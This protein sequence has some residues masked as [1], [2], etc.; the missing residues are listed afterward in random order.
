MPEKGKLNFLKNLHLIIAIVIVIIV[1]ILDIIFTNY[2][3]KIIQSLSD[4]IEKIENILKEDKNDFDEKNIE[5]L[6]KLAKQ[7]NNHWEKSS[8]TMTC[9]V[10]HEEVE[11]I[12]IKL[13][14]LEIELKN[15]LWSDAKRTTSEIKQLVDYLKDKYKLSIQ[16][17]F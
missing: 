11:K 3:S 17:I 12:N 13:H 9:F 4:N 14:M 6:E 16:N 5:E 10:E 7:T 15:S 8:E 2:S 1:I